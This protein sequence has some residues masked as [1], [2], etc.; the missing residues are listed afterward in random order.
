MGYGA[1]TYEPFTSQQ[2]H[3]KIIGVDEVDGKFEDT[4]RQVMCEFEVLGYEEQD[5]DNGE[6][7][8]W[9]FRDWFAFSVD[10]KTGTIGISQSPKAKLPALIKFALPN[11]KRLIEHGE[12]EPVMLMDA[13]IR[14]RVARSG[15]NEDGDH[16]RLKAETIM[17]KPKRPRQDAD[18]ED[19]DV[20]SLDMGDQPE[21]PDFS[22]IKEEVS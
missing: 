8:G 3:L 19:V 6:W 2:A 20:E 15:K 16:S 14:S 21:A 1:V 4:P 18:L 12:F 10:K 22:G 7:I 13:E 9:T 11:G 17:G 5:D